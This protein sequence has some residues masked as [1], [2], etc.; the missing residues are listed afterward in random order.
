MTWTDKQRAKGLA[1]RKAMSPEAIHAQAVRAGLARAA[2]ATTPY[3]ELGRLGGLATFAKRT[4]EEISAFARKGALATNARR[5][6][7]REVPGDS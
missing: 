7:Q 2:K 1:V 5:K 6:R 3:A 4:P